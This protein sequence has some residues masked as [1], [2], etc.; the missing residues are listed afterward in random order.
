MVIVLITAVAIYLD[1]PRETR[2]AADMTTAIRQKWVDEST[3]QLA[4]QQ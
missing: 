4:W 2:L 1:V 3:M